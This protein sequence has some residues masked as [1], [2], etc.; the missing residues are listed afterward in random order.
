MKV[1]KVTEKQISGLL[2][3]REAA[4]KKTIERDFF[5]WL[6]YLKFKKYE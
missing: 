3:M 5:F 2:T 4:K 6:S 1:K